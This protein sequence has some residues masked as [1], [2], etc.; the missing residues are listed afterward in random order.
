MHGSFDNYSNTRSTKHIEYK[1][2]TKIYT[3]TTCTC[4]PATLVNPFV[5]TEAGFWLKQKKID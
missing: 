1:G 3:P 4:I 2:I 5:T